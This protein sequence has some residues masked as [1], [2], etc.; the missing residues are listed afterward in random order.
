MVGALV[1]LFAFR[2]SVLA[3]ASLARGVYMG[4]GESLWQPNKLFR[5][6]AA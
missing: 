1:R 2:F 3:G 6:L 4:A 5:L